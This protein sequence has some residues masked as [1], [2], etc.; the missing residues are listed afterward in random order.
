MALSKTGNDRPI[1]SRTLIV[2]SERS[3]IGDKNSADSVKIGNNGGD[4]DSRSHLSFN[5]LCFARTIV[6]VL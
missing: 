6:F 4:G 3:A 5:N 1:R 2:G